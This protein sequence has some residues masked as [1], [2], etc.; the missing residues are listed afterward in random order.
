MGDFNSDGKTDILSSG[1]SGV[2]KLGVLL[3]NGDGTFGPI[4]PIQL[5][6]ATSAETGITVGDLNADGKLDMIMLGGSDG[7]IVFTQR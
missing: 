5:S 4:T 7:I 3:G 6:R 2:S 1:L